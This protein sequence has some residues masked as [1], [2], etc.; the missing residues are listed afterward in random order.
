ME[1]RNL[2]RVIESGI[3]LEKEG[4]IN[5]LNFAHKSKSM[6]GKNMFIRLAKDEYDHMIILEG[7]KSKIL[8]GK[9]MEKPKIPTEEIEGLMPKIKSKDG[10]IK[11]EEGASDIEALK[12]ALAFEKQ[13]ANYFAELAD[14]AEDE[15]TKKLARELSRWE[16][17]HYDLIQAEIDSITN[18]GF[19]FGVKE[20]EMSE[21]F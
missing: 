18:T 15:E 7:M 1:K 12:M 16:E 10:L 8:E 19:Y 3:A 13:A 2:V 21:R 11:G 14:K 6:T 20:F 9:V 4:L 5:Y 17:T